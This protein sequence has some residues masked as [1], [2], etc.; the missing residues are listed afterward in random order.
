MVY[1]FNLLLRDHTACIVLFLYYFK[2]IVNW[3]LVL[4]VFSLIFRIFSGEMSRMVRTFLFHLFSVY[5]SY[6]VYTRCIRH[7]FYFKKLPISKKVQYIFLLPIYF[8]EKIA[9]KKLQSELYNKTSNV[10]KINVIFSF[11]QNRQKINKNCWRRTAKVWTRNWYKPRQGKFN[12][13]FPW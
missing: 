6:S 11:G 12:F 8:P 10:W 9:K 13:D 3:K 1:G 5:H 7:D 2:L 4:K